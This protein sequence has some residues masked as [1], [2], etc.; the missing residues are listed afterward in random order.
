MTLTKTQ[1]TSIIEGY[2]T[3]EADTGSPEVQIAILS[4]R[5]NSLT[6]HFKSHAKDHHSRRGL[7]MLVGQ[8]RRL[9]D[10]LKG[11]DQ[12]RYRSIIE[13]LGIRK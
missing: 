1:K 3:H 10:Y 6:E 5:I 8:R 4:E 11:K 13:K 2:R 7:M 9:L 12:K